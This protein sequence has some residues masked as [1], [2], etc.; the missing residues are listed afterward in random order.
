[1]IARDH[2][3]SVDEGARAHPPVCPICSEPMAWVPQIG[4]M[5]FLATPFE[6]LDG[7]NEP[8]FIDT[9]SKLRAV[10]RESEK[11][12]ADGMGQSLTWR[13]YSQTHS[14]QG[15]NTHGPD[16]S[17]QPTEESKKR[18]APVRHGELMPERDYGPAVNDSNASALSE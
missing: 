2:Y 10:E 7:K 13:M 4:R 1:M 5:D 3:R 11:L 12:A 8:V 16:P 6:A 18:F 14:N 9:L 15:V 17:E